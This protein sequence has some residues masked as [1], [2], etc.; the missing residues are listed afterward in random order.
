MLDVKKHGFQTNPTSP[1]QIHRICWIM[2]LLNSKIC[3]DCI[4][5]KILAKPFKERCGF[6]KCAKSIHIFWNSHNNNN[7]LFIACAPP[8]AH[9]DDSAQYTCY[10]RAATRAR[11]GANVQEIDQGAWAV[12]QARGCR[13]SARPA[14][15]ARATARRQLDI[16]F[17]NVF[18][19]Y[20]IEI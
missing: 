12:A 15:A 20:V 10:M 9:R 6:L 13:A 18:W 19:V 7:R 1:A 2:K 16:M 14:N 11:R 3:V 4:T 17:W 5:H 8:R